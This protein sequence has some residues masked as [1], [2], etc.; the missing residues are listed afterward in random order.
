M[1]YSGLHQ[2]FRHGKSLIISCLGTKNCQST[3]RNR[4]DFTRHYNTLHYCKPGAKR[5]ID[6]PVP[7]C[8]RVGENGFTRRDN[9]LQ[10]RRGLH[11]EDIPKSR[12]RFGRKRARVNQLNGAKATTGGKKGKHP[13]HKISSE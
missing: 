5:L 6:C 11:G 8:Q 12:V 7:G 10:H 3:F 9:L 13:Y 4:N 2:C 1:P